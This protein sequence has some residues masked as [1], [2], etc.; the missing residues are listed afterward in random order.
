MRAR[1]TA[2]AKK[3]A[4]IQHPGWGGADV[5]FLPFPGAPFSGRFH[6]RYGAVLESTT[7]RV[8]TTEMCLRSHP[9]GV[10]DA[11][12]HLKVKGKRERRHG[13]QSR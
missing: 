2:C 12:S 1:C 7:R 8:P 11:T 10:I 6:L 9:E 4:T 13:S 5:G 3:G